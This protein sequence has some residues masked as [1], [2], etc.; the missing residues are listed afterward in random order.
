MRLTLALLAL[1]LPLGSIGAQ[2]F[3]AVGAP[4]DPKV[5]VAWNRYYDY[6]GITDICRRLAKAFPDLVRMES[7]GRSTQGREMWALTVTDFK[8]GGDAARKP[9]FYIDGNIHS[10]EIQGTEVALYTAWYLAE[11]HGR[12]GMID[13]LLEGRVF[14]IVPTIN[15]DAREDFMKKPNTMHSP[16]SGMAPRDDDGDGLVDEDGPDD[17][18]GDGSIT[19]MRRRDVNGRWRASEEDPRMMVRAKAGEPGTHEML[20]EEGI[21]NDGDGLVN[22]DGP[23][24]YDPNRDWGWNWQ[25][26][27]V[28]YGADRYPF[29][30]QENRNVRDFVMSHPNIAG[31]QSYHNAGGM[32]LRP[33]G[34][35]E[36][37]PTFTSNDVEVYDVIGKRG[38]QMLPGYKYMTTYKDLYTTYGGEV[39]WFYS[40]R[41]VYA[42]TNE[43]WS[44]FNMFGTRHE[45]WFGNRKDLYSFDRFVLF[46]EGIVD[47][48]TVEHPQYGPVEVGGATKNYTR[49]NPSFLIE[50]MAHRNMAFTLY[51]AWQMPQVVVQKV[52]RRRLDGGLTE[53]TATIANTRVIP[54]RTE[55]DVR[56]G[57]SRADLVTIAG[58]TVLSGAIVADRNLGL[59]DEQKHRP[60]RIAVPS[61]P[62]Q[63]Y[64]TVRWIVKGSGPFTVTVDSQKG[65][66]AIAEG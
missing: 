6:D 15:P 43:L 45:E 5:E 39:D 17:L 36:D 38:E 57:I 10:N 44:S 18:D 37:A 14:Y 12:V 55:W 23:G 31:A 34:A 1:I 63:G 28:Q 26:R 25:P 11:M 61:I 62:G 21:D 40:M 50:E 32:I 22:E 46:G 49:I 54:T 59:A 7:I 56:N 27:Y 48:H 19:Q 30:L 60:E 53:V 20:E 9:G 4:A 8:R 16:R 33:P 66:V 24:F 52:D 35:E 42:F 64:V 65:G 41:G 13:T 29:T 47:W 58:G 2:D 3:K 51:H